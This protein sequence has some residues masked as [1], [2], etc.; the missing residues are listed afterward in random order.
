MDRGVKM[1]V[2]MFDSGIGGLTV[3]DACARLNLS[4]TFYYLGDNGHA[5]YGNRPS[6]EITTF[7][8]EAL[9][10][11]A[12]LNVDAAV[13]ACNTATAVCADILRAEY[14]FPIVGME[15]AVKPA[16]EQCER[17]LVLA[18]PRTAESDR[19]RA[20]IKRFPERQFTVHAA[21]GLAAAVEERF[22]HGKPLELSEYLPKGNFDGIVLGCTH[23][24]FL[25]KEISDFYGV[26]VF[27]GA[28][29]TAERLRFLLMKEA[30]KRGEVKNPKNIGIN[31]H[32]RHDKNPNNCF[33]Q[34]QNKRGNFEVFFLGN[35][36]NPNKYLFEREFLLK[37]S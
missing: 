11:F 8:R 34:N 6:A 26:P 1:C 7:V 4:C 29:G 2:G 32:S 5:P 16:A 12:E 15:P 27:D 30:E 35:Y 25:K 20:L 23:Y 21:E 18:T 31:D 17:V 3:L 33:S 36:K 14:S 13:L 10:Q 9:D 19:L 28:L 24:L 22:L 37:K